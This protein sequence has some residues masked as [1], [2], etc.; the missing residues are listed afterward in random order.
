MGENVAKARQAKSAR[1]EAY[2]KL[3]SEEN[4]QKEDKLNYL[5]SG[6]RLGNSN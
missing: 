4:R 5:T 2:D 3:M 1:L 6:S